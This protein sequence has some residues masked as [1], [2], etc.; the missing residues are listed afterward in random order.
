MSRN[1]SPEERS[2]P[3]H[4]GAISAGDLVAAFHRLVP[5]DDATRRAIADVLGVGWEREEPP[6]SEPPRPSPEPPPPPRW[7]EPAEPPRPTTPPRSAEPD[8]RSR[9]QEVASRLVQVRSASR[10]APAWL[11]R[12]EPLEMPS[13]ATQAAPAQVEPLFAPGYTRSILGIAL[14]NEIDSGEIDLE[15]VVD[16][17]SRGRALREVPRLPV[18]SLAHGVQLLLD[19][20]EAMLP[21]LRDLPQIERW[22]RRTAGEDRVEVLRFAACPSRGAG[23]GSIRTRSDYW[24]RH[25]PPRGVRVLCVT[26]LGIGEPVRG[27]PPATVEEWL[28]FHDRLH[29]AGCPLLVLNPYHPERWPPELAARIPI[30]HWSRDANAGSAARAVRGARRPV[31]PTPAR[32]AAGDEDPVLRLARAVSLAVRAEP[33][34]VRK[35][36]LHLVPEADPGLEADLWFHPSVRHASAEGIVLD[37]EAGEELRRRLAQE[38]PERYEETWRLTREC[39]AALSPALRVEEE[40]LYLV[41]SRRPEARE[42]IRRLLAS[43]LAA[44]VAGERRGLAQWAARA[45]PRF[46]AEVRELEEAVMLAAAADLRLE[47]RIVS[48]GADLPRPPEEWLPWIAPAARA[49]VGV[50]LLRG[51]LQAT[52]PPPE[53][54]GH[55]VLP[56]LRTDPVVLEI[57]EEDGSERGV[58]RLELREGETRTIEVR[59][60][61]VRLRTLLGEEYLLEATEEARE[62]D[63][64]DFRGLIKRSQPVY[65]WEFPERL[66]ELFLEGDEPGYVLVVGPPGA[67]KTALVSY[68]ARTVRYQSGRMAP[69]HFFRKGVP[70]WAD[71][72]RAERSLVAQ[73]EAVVPDQAILAS[74]SLSRAIETWAGSHDPKDR[75]LIL[76]DGLEQATSQ[77]AL[78]EL[79]P[80]YLPRGVRIACTVRSDDL[81]EGWL[82]KARPPLE[83]LT[84]P[85]PTPDLLRRLPELPRLSKVLPGTLERA[86]RSWGRWWLPAILRDAE[87]HPFAYEL[88][89]EMEGLEE[90]RLEDLARGFWEEADER[91]RRGWAGTCLAREALPE[92]L[93]ATFVS[94]KP[95][96]VRN[97][98][99]LEVLLDR[100]GGPTGDSWIP[101]SDV[102]ADALKGVL[103]EE[104]IRATHEDFVRGI[105]AWPS[106]LAKAARLS[107]EQREEVRRFALRHALYHAARADDQRTIDE[108]VRDFDYLVERLRLDGPDPLIADLQDVLDVGDLVLELESGERTAPWWDLLLET[109]RQERR[110]L[111]DRPEALASL[112]Y[113]RMRELARTDPRWDREGTLR[114][115]YL[116]NEHLPELWLH[117]VH[118]VSTGSGRQEEEVEVRGHLGLVRGV[119]WLPPGREELLSWGAD[120][121]VLLWNV[122]SGTPRPLGTRLAGEITGC[123]P[124]GGTGSPDKIAVACRDGTVGLFSLS[125]PDQHAE[126]RGHEG[127]VLGVTALQSGRFA[128]FSEDGTLRVW[129]YAGEPLRVLR[130]HDGAVTVAARVRDG[131]IAS[132]GVDG[133]VRIW[134]PETGEEHLLLEGHTAPI[135][136]LALG[137]EYL[138]TAAEDATIRLWRLDHLAPGPVLQGH[139]LAVTAVGWSGPMVV[140]GSLDRTVRTWHSASGS[141]WAEADRHPAAVTGLAFPRERLVVACADGRLAVGPTR[142]RRRL[143]SEEPSFFDAHSLPCRGCAVAP[144]DKRLASWSDDGSIRIWDV[145]TGRRLASLEE[146]EPPSRPLV[147]RSRGWLAFGPGSPFEVHLDREDVYGLQGP[148]DSR[149]SRVAVGGDDLDATRV[150]FWGDQGVEMAELIAPSPEGRGGAAQI[151]YLWQQRGSAT[152]EERPISAVAVVADGVAT[153][154]ETVLE[155]WD[156]SR[157]LSMRTG[158][159]RRITGLHPLG[160]ERLLSWSWDG[161]LRVHSIAATREEA[162]LEGHRGPVLACAVDRRRTRALSAAADASLRLWNLEN[163]TLLQVWEEG[164]PQVTALFLDPEIGLFLAGSSE[165]RVFAL[166]P[167]SATPARGEGHDGPVRAF[168]PDPESNAPR[169]YSTGDDGTLRLWELGAGGEI[170]LLKTAYADSGLLSVSA[171]GN[172]VA[173]QDR[174]GNLWIY[175]HHPPKGPERLPVLVRA[176]TNVRA[177]PDASSAVVGTVEGGA[178]L[179]VLGGEGPWL[180]VEHGPQDLIGWVHRRAVIEEDDHGASPS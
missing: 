165:G 78:A 171:L 16:G 142:E 13:R 56:V 19:R 156:E 31:R 91:L 98:R 137:Q 2:S 102:L 121:R 8:E 38:S 86:A 84:P 104:E 134:N 4:R 141:E 24:V 158:H 123:A 155:R 144:D 87:S 116:A 21:F 93:L 107:E 80:S 92:G 71:V 55:H 106:P 44:L 127:P 138:A 170:R 159:R 62:R 101:R 145:K 41:H 177:E 161:T 35:V 47:G 36:R 43:A 115:F 22:V 178:Y 124:V 90:P 103:D 160:G 157:I 99:S 10:Q 60:D 169:F 3:V 30:L 40:V 173:A 122:E 33:E 49:E 25:R 120:G 12:A 129:S 130:G 75:L 148:S 63:V 113:N 26:D 51:R 112:V 109:L 27:Q 11:D 88:L 1:S 83:T 179:D 81:V 180:Q 147:I 176:R 29:K 59:G 111:R 53:G 119:R 18:A 15:S 46:P 32:L 66:G 97:P 77:D 95:G 48:G 61:G 23:A 164:P 131:Q 20:S 105:T 96:R 14:A 146:P 72:R 133:T 68:L 175:R 132:G 162:V 172:A 58:R 67:G 154:R 74:P 28:E 6:R 57:L 126:L 70:A 17:I 125:A 54:N 167:G 37:P 143:G 114:R 9:S 39:H 85:A 150:V 108:L 7:S 76:L 153:A 82:R 149:A 45:L 89:Q 110:R 79:L 136:V 5:G 117:R 151:E 42:R 52:T 163:H 100:V 135:T 166:S 73:V 128:T 69:H 152:Q 174:W 65:D 118:R 34:L 140:S 64:I 168:T 50:R 94:G 139:E